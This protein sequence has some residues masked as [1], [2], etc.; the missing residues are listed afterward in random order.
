MFGPGVN[1]AS[2]MEALSEPMHITM[3]QDTFK[4]LED[5]FDYTERGEFEVKGFGTQTLYFLDSE[6]AAPL[7]F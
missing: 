5:D 4:L 2:R 1:L 3:N 6:K 7:R